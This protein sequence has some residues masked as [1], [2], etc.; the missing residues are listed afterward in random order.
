LPRYLWFRTDSWLGRYFRKYFLGI[1]FA[2]SRSRS[3]GRG[4]RAARDSNHFRPLVAALRV[5]LRASEG[6]SP[7]VQWAGWQN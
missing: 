4:A 6:D 7:L 2:D 5:L 1:G 3:R